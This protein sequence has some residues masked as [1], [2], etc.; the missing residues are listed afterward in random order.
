MT[1]TIKSKRAGKEKTMDPIEFI[2]PCLCL[3][4]FDKR[5]KVQFH[6]DYWLLE[7]DDVE[8]K[9]FYD[10]KVEAE[11]VIYDYANKYNRYED[12]ILWGGRFYA[13]S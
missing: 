10:D 1:I 9:E 13:N 5:Y 8:L 4:E 6:R 12:E 11:S 7:Y 2:Y 3:R